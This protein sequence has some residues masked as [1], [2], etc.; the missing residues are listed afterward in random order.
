MA[1]R[2]TDQ[3]G[4]VT[5]NVTTG[6][7]DE[8]SIGQLVADVSRDLSDIVR[9]EIALAKAELQADVR[10]GAVGGGMFAAAGYFAFL[11]VILLVIAAAYGLTETGLP[12]WAS[13]L[14]VAG[15]LL[16]IGGILVVIGV[17]R[18]KK[19]GPPRRA[20]QSTKDTLAAVRPGGQNGS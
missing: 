17:S 14:I 15:G 3:A 18:F 6:A 13:F 12:A 2:S 8:R 11:A 7:P 9:H 1:N 16:L 20:I 10:N 4:P 19:L 5:I